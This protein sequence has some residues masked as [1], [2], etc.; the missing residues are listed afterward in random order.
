M[1]KSKERDKE[2]KRRSSQIKEPIK[3]EEEGQ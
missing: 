3:A 1:K 2:V